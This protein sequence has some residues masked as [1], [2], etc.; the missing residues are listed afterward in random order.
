M[1]RSRFTETQ[2]VSILKEA[3]AGVKVKDLCRK[4]GISDAT[5]YNWKSKYGGMEACPERSWKR[6]S[7]RLDRSIMP[8]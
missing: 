4:H 1:K 6:C 3:D 8:A 5:Y 7:P 2:I